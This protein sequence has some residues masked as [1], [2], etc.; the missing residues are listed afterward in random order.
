MPRMTVSPVFGVLDRF[1]DTIV[2]FLFFFGDLEDEIGT[3]TV[4]TWFVKTDF[5]T[6]LVAI[7]V[8]GASLEKLLGLV[9]GRDTIQC[10]DQVL[11]QNPGVLARIETSIH[12][13]LHGSQRSLWRLEH[14]CKNFSVVSKLCSKKKE[15]KY[16]QH[17]Q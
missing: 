16:C 9:D 8:A 5:I 13:R 6:H 17:V 7:D 2:F 14:I 12:Q 10:R 11:G 1:P 15:E 4:E 3:L